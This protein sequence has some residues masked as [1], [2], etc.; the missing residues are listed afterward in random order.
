MGC[1][2]V[3]MQ[4]MDL[5]LVTIFP[6]IEQFHFL[7]I[8]PST[9]HISSNRSDEGLTGSQRQPLNSLRW[10]IYVFSSVVN[11]KLQCIT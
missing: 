8:N 3:Y 1:V 2:W 11:T 9:T 7:H 10:L 4:K 6:P 5:L